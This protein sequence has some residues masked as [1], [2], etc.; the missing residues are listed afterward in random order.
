[1]VKC[2]DLGEMPGRDR[3]RE[4]HGRTWTQGSLEEWIVT[5]SSCAAGADMMRKSM[6]SLVMKVNSWWSITRPDYAGLYRP[7][8]H[9]TNLTL[10]VLI[11]CFMTCELPCGEVV[12]WASQCWKE[13]KISLT[14][15]KGT[16]DFCVGRLVCIQSNRAR[17][18]SDMVRA[19]RP[20]TNCVIFLPLLL[21][22]A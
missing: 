4:D 15:Y 22:L 2:K 3:I 7:K 12:S 8:I 1:M 6:T 11:N 13:V 21:S 17:N 9:T 14:V 5:D 18:F 19:H 20:W 10:L 16:F